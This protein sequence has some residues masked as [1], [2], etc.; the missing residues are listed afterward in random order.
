MIPTSHSS[1]S[2]FTTLST[3]TNTNKLFSIAVV[4]SWATHFIKTKLWFSQRI[5]LSYFLSFRHLIFHILTLR[6]STNI[7]CFMR[8]IIVTEN[9]SI[10]RRGD[11]FIFCILTSWIENNVALSRELRELVIKEKA[12]FWNSVL[13]LL[14]Y[15]Q[16]KSKFLFKVQQY[17]GYSVSRIKLDGNCNKL[18]FGICWGAI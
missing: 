1:C 14:K 13:S 7:K 6:N 9:L 18:S 3:R 17:N 10:S 5:S 2:Y 12:I 4:Y 11:I 15:R 8:S 16:H